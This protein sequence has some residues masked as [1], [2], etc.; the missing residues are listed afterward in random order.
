MLAAP[1]RVAHFHVDVRP[2]GEEPRPFDHYARDRQEA[3][4]LAAAAADDGF[5]AR[6]RRCSRLCPPPEVY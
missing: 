1:H 3:R 6:I 2:G 5:W 4:R